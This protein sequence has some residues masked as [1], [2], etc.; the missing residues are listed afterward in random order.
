MLVFRAVRPLTGR[1]PAG[2]GDDPSVP[3][4]PIEFQDALG[5]A[6]A[7]VHENMEPFSDLVINPRTRPGFRA[8][9]KLDAIL[10]VDLLKISPD[11]QHRLSGTESGSS[12]IN[13][14]VPAHS[15]G[16]RGERRHGSGIQSGLIDRCSKGMVR[17]LAGPPK[18]GRRFEILFQGRLIFRRVST[19]LC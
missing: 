15:G 3:P 14:K 19:R 2:S 13:E 10:V 8:A 18:T 6:F 5:L 12:K 11:A 1:A 9:A 17:I 7:I 16:H 4:I